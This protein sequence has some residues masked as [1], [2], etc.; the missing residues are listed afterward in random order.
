MLSSGL[1]LRITKYFLD[2]FKMVINRIFINKILLLNK[3]KIPKTGI[4]NHNII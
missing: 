4:L 1:K 2:S 3:K